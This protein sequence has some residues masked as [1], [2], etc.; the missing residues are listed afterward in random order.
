MAYQQPWL[1]DLTVTLAAPTAVLGSGDGQIRDGGVQGV[2]HSDVRVL[3]RAEL[4]V[5]GVEPVALAGGLDGASSARFTAIA[6][7]LGDEGP[8]PTVRVE[9]SRRVVCGLVEEEIRIVSFAAVPVDTQAVL[10]LGAD[11]AGVEAVKQGHPPEPVAIDLG[12]NELSWGTDGVSVVVRAEGAAADVTGHGVAELRWPVRLPPRGTTTLRW[13]L[14]ADVDGAPVTGAPADYWTDVEIEHDGDH[15][16][17]HLVRRSLADLRA[18]LMAPVGEPDAVFAAAGAPWYFTL[19]GR[20]S[21][22][23]ARLMLPFGWELA[24]GTLRALA[25]RQGTKTDPRTME[26]PG[27]IP[28]ELRR[29][30]GSTWLPPL[31]YGTVDATPLWVCL[32]HDA[33]RAGMPEDQVRAL[34][35]NLRA[36]LTWTVELGDEDGDGFLEYLDRGGDG[37]SNQGWKDSFDS[38]RFRDGT[39]AT[40]PVALCEAQG[41]AYEAAVHGADLLD[42][43][44]MEGGDPLR[45]WA[46]RLADRFQQQFWVQD[47]QGPYPALALD[48]HKRPVDS[49][50]SNIGHLLGT[51]LLDEA[52]SALVVDRLTAPG[53]DSGFGLR[54]MDSREAGY[55]PLSYHCG[56]VWPHDT[57]IAIWSMTRAGFADRATGL[58]NGLIAAAERFDYRLPELYSGDGPEQGPGVAPY[59]AACRPQAWAAASIGAIAQCLG[60]DAKR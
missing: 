7:T 13:T 5:A 54:T 25:A 59:P 51:G 24:A 4:T 14:W 17:A 32:L 33:W 48:G 42:A 1:H 9:R 26:A 44:G 10:T 37:L 35:P 34:L 39:L 45:A 43:F 60:L 58:V 8:D 38:I 57:A 11:S 31:Y 28:H 22:W 19:F 27:K 23:T 15:R 2:L 49:L 47:E 40:G 18:L 21:L 3:S 29:P 53:M 12:D 56:S 30:S 16:L 55:S 36:A 20:D 41:Y 46:A 52:Q 50:T 6:R